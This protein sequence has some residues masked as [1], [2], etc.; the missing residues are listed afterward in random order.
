M[1]NLVEELDVIGC[2]VLNGLFS[3][4][5]VDN[6]ERQLVGCISAAAGTRNLLKHEWCGKLAIYLR[7]HPV[8]ATCLP[9]N[10]AAVQCTFFEKSDDNNWLVALHRDEFI[11]VKKRIEV[12][13]W[14][15]WSLKEGTEFVRPPRSVLE[16]LI[17]IRVAIDSNNSQNGPLEIVPGS[18]VN[19]FLSGNRV[20]F[21]VKRGGALILKPLLLHSS[22]KVK[23]GR[24]R[25]L[26]YLFG[27]ERLPDGAEW[28]HAV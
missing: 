12:A 26:H 16:Q 14:D 5:E 7:N 11:P 22:S 19:E 18:H 25:V 27:P 2:S 8:L 3:E 21:H 20:A 6:I 10:M 17:G 28:A 23:R 9:E 13:G 15:L 4:T 24:R 1:C